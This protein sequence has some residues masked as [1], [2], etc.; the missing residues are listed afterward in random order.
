MS[1]AATGFPDPAPVIDLIEAFRRSKAMFAAVSLGVFERLA[2]ER[3][4]AV[5]LAAQIRANPDAVERL[6][7]ACAGLGFLEKKNTTYS[8]TPV[9]LTYLCRSSPRTMTG[10]IL[11]SN[12]LLYPLWGNL[13][14]AVREGTPRWMQTFQMEGPIFAHFFK[15][16]ESKQEFLAGMHGFG[17][18][19]SPQV[20]AAFD[21]S[22][23]RRLVD[24]GGATGHLV[25]AACERYPT[26]RAAVFDL[27]PV[28]EVARPY[29]SGSQVGERVELL[30][31]DFFC[32]PLPEADL[33]SLGRILHDWSEAKIRGLLGRIYDRLPRGGALLI[34]ER[35]LEE[36]KTGPTFALMQSL[37]MLVCT[38]GKE[39]TFSEYAA[40]LREAGFRAVEARRTGA[41]LDAILAVRR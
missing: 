19:S 14:D 16:E 3:S 40:L 25:I 41:P 32:D 37:N 17:L 20:V 15:T 23:F 39:R 26:M 18:I 36:E 38:E 11:Y 34:A 35:L 21:L 29:V 10:Y 27:A 33:F 13:E 31:G 28:I 22:G 2:E 7:D 1:E 6:L 4:D 30:A 8:C 24:L 5:T 9:A 12:R